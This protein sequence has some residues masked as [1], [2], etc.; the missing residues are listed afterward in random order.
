MLL[1]NAIYTHVLR[2]YKNTLS[3]NIH[4]AFSTLRIFSTPHFLRSA[5]STLRTPHST[6]HEYAA[7][8]FGVCP[9]SVIFLFFCLR[10]HRSARTLTCFAFLSTDFREKKET[11]RTFRFI[12]LFLL[13]SYYRLAC[14]VLI[15]VPRV[16][17]E[18]SFVRVW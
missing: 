16:G 18:S 14:T 11:A 6:N 7:F 13:E 10:H 9:K 1:I 4:S 5:F 12:S 3:K 15:I 2:Y 17:Y 8:L